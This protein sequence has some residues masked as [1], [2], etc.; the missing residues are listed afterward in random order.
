MAAGK[1]VRRVC[2]LGNAAGVG[3]TIWYAKRDEVTAIPEATA[4]VITGAFTMATTPAA[5]TF[6]IMDLSPI[7][8]KKVFEE[9]PAGDVDSPSWTPT[10][11]GFHP[12]VE[13]AKNAVLT[14]LAGCEYIVVV[15]DK[16]K[17][18]WLVGDKDAGATITVKP[19]INEGSNGYEI[20]ITLE[21]ASHL[22]YELH[23]DTT[24]A[25]S[26]T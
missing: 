10:I 11:T 13:G 5:G 14:S 2:G 16:N 22:A 8:N 26:E 17:R 23:E 18:R 21:G 15:Q 4:G 19:T 3:N 24:F 6:N 12:K 25:I 20:T 1:N 7:A 9:V